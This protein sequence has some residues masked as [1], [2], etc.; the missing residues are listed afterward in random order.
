MKQLQPAADGHDPAR[1]ILMGRHHIN[2]LRPDLFQILC[3]D[4]SFVG[5]YRDCLP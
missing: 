3:P 4:P 5:G 2:R 1:G